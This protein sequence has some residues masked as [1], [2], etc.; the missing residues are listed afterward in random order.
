MKKADWIYIN[1]VSPPKYIRVLG[2][3]R[4]SFNGKKRSLAVGYISKVEGVW[5]LQD[6]ENGI[7]GL[8]EV[9]YWQHIRLPG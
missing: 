4:S 9:E 6:E 3:G 5:V 8:Y 2:I 7:E 1:R